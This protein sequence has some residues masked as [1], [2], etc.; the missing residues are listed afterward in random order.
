MTHIIIPPGAFAPF[1]WIPGL[2]T[3]NQPATSS[4]LKILTQLYGLLHSQYVLMPGSSW[5]RG[6]CSSLEVQKQQNPP[7]FVLSLSICVNMCFKK[8]CQC[9]SHFNFATNTE[10]VARYIRDGQNK[11]ASRCVE[12]LSR[13]T[14]RLSYMTSPFSK[15]CVFRSKLT[16]FCSNVT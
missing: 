8:L 1:R 14:S 15:T 10:L 3:I 11:F 5:F 6:L 13:M 12:Q 7:G 4:D 16:S 2:P 9:F